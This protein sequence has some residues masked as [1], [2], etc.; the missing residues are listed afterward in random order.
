MTPRWR[1]LHQ[2][3]LIP[4]FF[5]KNIQSLHFV[6]ELIQSQEVTLHQLLYFL[7]ID[8]LLLRIIDDH[9]LGKGQGFGFQELHIVD[10][11]LFYD[12]IPK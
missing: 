12:D 5:L 10:F 4:T 6:D 11:I 7:H 3:F 8:S 2:F 1:C 9:V